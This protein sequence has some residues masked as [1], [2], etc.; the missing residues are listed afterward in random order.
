M[1]VETRLQACISIPHQKEKLDAFSSILDDI[2]LSNN[3]H[4]LKSYIDAVLNE[5]VNLVIS[6]QL[7][8]EFIAL[9]NHKITN[10]ATQ[11]ELLLYAI[12]RTQPRAVS[13]EESVKKSE[14]E[15][16]DKLN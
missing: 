10:H 2:L 7:L 16:R 9:F 6:R 12:S 13:F 1:D 3:T 15:K 4:D 5:Q 8:S 11:K 14:K